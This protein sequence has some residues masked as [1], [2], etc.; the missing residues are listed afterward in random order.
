MDGK[1]VGVEDQVWETLL[2]TA[3]KGYN[4][5]VFHPFTMVPSFLTYV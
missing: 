5:A 4:H 2:Y 3:V 1:R